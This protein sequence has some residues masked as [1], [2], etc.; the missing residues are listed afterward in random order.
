MRFVGLFVGLCL[1]LS[2]GAFAAEETEKT[3]TNLLD[4]ITKGTFK[5]NLRYRY[6]KVDQDGFDKK[7]QASTL[8]TMAGY[9]TGTW[10]GL[11][12]YLEF[13]DIRDLGFSN[14][15][16]NKGAG[17]LWNGVTDRPVIADP[18]LTEI[19]Q[20]Y[21]GWKP[22]DS[23]PFRFGLQEI[24]IDNH[25]FVGNV[26]W[27][28]NH[29]TFEAARGDFTGVKNLKISYSYIGRQHTVTGASL[30]MGTSHL[31]LSYAFG[32]IGT[33]KGYGMLLEYD[34][35]PHWV[36][37]SM[38]FGAFFDGNAKLSEK[39]KLG[40][41]IEYANQTDINDNPNSIN[42][43]YIRADLGLTVSKVAFGIGYEL[44]GGS[45]GDGQFNTPLATL[46]KFNG[47]ADKFLSTPAHG[48]QDLYLT[49][50]AKLG[51]WVLV[52]MY[53]DFSADSGGFDWGT[54]L[55]AAVIWTAPWKQKFSIK[56]SDYNA[57]DHATDTKKLWLWTSWGF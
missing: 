1:V 10:K 23:L 33:L 49:I 31:G 28:Q 11:E 16:N 41:R 48:L 55:D 22:I 37:N 44:L 5:L 42:A 52:G 8:R 2:T 6:E 53:H 17:S 14:D 4:A 13:E 19:N 3:D 39:L 15:H 45:P 51:S 47:W 26:L 7:G 25:R 35:E 29:Q 18:P 54:E 56:Y 57:K 32:K 27:R 21:L 36:K 20:A 24:I 12:V 34:D 38:T 40:Y 9:K 30:P 43:D 50:N 46:H